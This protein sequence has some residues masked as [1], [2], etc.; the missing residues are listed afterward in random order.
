MIGIKFLAGLG[1]IFIFIG[2]YLYKEAFGKKPV[3]NLHDGKSV[4]R[5]TTYG[6]SVQ[7]FLGTLCVILGILL[8]LKAMR[9]I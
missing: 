9:L 1:T 7:V 5:P 6:K 4:N 2:Y 3:N 8:I